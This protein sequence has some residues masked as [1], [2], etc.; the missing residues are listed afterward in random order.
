VKPFSST[1]TAVREHEVFHEP[2]SR[3]T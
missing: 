1:P 3:C 2:F